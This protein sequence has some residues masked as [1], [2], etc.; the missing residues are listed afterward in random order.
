MN[1]GKMKMDGSMNMS[2]MNMDST[3]NMSG[4]SMDDDMK[5]PGMTHS[6]SLSLPMQRDGSGTS[7]NPDNSPMA[8]I[9]TMQKKSMWMFHGS[10][11]LRYDDQQLNGKTLR[12]GEK[13]DAPNWLM[14]MHNREVGKH[15]LFN[16]TSMIS[17][18]PLTVGSAGYPLLFQTGES[19]RGLPL[20]DKQHPHDLFS[21]LSVAY[22]QRLN[23]KMDA[24]VYFGYPGEPALGPVAFMHRVSAMDDPDAPLSHHWQD[25]TH[26]T[27]GVATIGFRYENL[28][29]E[30]SD[31]TGREPDENRYD[32]DAMKFDSYAYRLSWNPDKHWALQYSQAFIK[33]PELL[34][35]SENVWRYTASAIYATP[36]KNEHFFNAS[37]VWGMNVESS[38]N[39]T[40]SA[41]IELS[42]QFKKQAIYSR[43][44]FVQKNAEELALQNVPSDAVYNINEWTIGTNRK[45]LSFGKINLLGGL[46]FTGYF[47]PPSLK[48]LYGNLPLAG[49][50]YLQ[51]RPGFSK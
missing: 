44:E 50:I 27:F 31:F 1:N 24:F 18:D 26:I 43:Y 25:A 2:G 19:Y 15:G 51:L 11:F 34:H 8:M 6:Y 33:S 40:N 9:M 32:F 36:I 47:P 35:P 46:Q 30:L 5:M 20:V 41:L 16:F 23:K 4:M 14:A 12:S 13:P 7:W 39:K 3:M 10:I 45:F 48:N 29:L 17:L 42:Q 22:T 38:D 21:A 28:K 49:E 37:L